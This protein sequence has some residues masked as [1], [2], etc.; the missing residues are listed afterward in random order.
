MDLKYF[1]DDGLKTQE[2]GDWAEKKY[3]LVTLYDKL[4]STGMKRKW[5]K[6]IYIDLFCGP[7]R[8]KLR[9]RNKIVNGSPLIALDLPDP[10]DKYIFCDKEEENIDVLKSRINE[11]KISINAN[12]I[13]GDCNFEVEKIL[14]LIKQEKDKILSFCFVDPFSLQNLSFKTVK[15]LSSLRMDFLILL[16]SGYDV[17]RNEEIYV[18]EESSNLDKFLGY[19]K[20]RDNWSEEKGNMK[21][22]EFFLR[23]YIN[24][25]VKLG[26]IKQTP[27]DFIEV[28]TEKNLLLYHLAFFSK[29]KRGYE[30]W[31]KVKKY[32]SSQ[33]SFNF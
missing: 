16:P 2:V 20:W 28:R 27:S 33:T 30:F 15:I 18:N 23:E 13:I 17:R 24:N 10:F 9:D 11:L 21:F 25:I 8:V 1:N 31:R 3:K 12:Y 19:S 4:F 5:D 22:T 32:S 6:R 14:N 29:H 7:G 26:Y